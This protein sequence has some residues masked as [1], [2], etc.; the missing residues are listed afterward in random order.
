MT[1]LYQMCDLPLRLPDDVIAI[2]K[3]AFTVIIKLTILSN[4]LNSSR[5]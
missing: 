4:L 3:V 5:N 1:D 2:T